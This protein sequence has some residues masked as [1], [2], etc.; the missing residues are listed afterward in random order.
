[1]VADGAAPCSTRSEGVTTVRAVLHALAPGIYGQRFGDGAPQVVALHGWGRSSSD[2]VQVLGGM[3]AIAVDLPGFGASAAP[4]TSIGAAGYADALAPI[5]ESLTSSV[6]VVGHSFG[7]RIAAVLG[8]R[9]VPNVAGV[10][11]TG[12]PLVRKPGWKPTPPPLGFRLARK[13]HALG[14]LSD[15]GIERRRRSRGSADYR[16]ATG[17]MR[18]IL[19]RVVNETYDD[20]LRAL[21]LPAWF[22][23]GE[24]DTDVPVA[25]AHEAARL[26]THSYPVQELAGVGHLVPTKAPAELRSAIDDA[27]RDS[28]A[29]A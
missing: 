21:S 11:F 3:S 10:L 29:S 23:W 14:L 17:V 9:A 25:I 5:F 24:N 7:G 6:V 19:V 28:V 15:A 8:A 13:A 27:V 22:V 2:F 18:D 16:A 1:M 20:E 26:V 12:A 4:N